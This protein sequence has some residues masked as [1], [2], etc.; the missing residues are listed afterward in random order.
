MRI[1]DIRHV[2]K[3][4]R[5]VSGCNIEINAKS[6]QNEI[7]RSYHCLSKNLLNFVLY[8]RQ[9]HP[10]INKSVLFIP[11]LLAEASL[12]HTFWMGFPLNLDGLS[13]KWKKEFRK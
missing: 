3:R 4:L 12:P 8:M 6:K 7:F 11:I 13:P 10:L 5:N 9:K 2:T 1:R